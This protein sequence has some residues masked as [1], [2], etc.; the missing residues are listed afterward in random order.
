MNEIISSIDDILFWM[1]IFMLFGSQLR[2][3]SKTGDDP[4]AIKLLFSALIFGVLCIA[5]RLQP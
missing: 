4:N 5:T 2:M 1:A 3:I